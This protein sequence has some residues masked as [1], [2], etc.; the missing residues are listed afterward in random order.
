MLKLSG[1][2]ATVFDVEVKGNIANA[3]IT[4]SKKKED[5]SYENMRW[6]ARFAGKNVSQ[7]AGQLKNGDR[8]EIVEGAVEN[9]YDGEKGYTNVVIFR[10]YKVEGGNE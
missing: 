1:S 10:F 6:L 7:K 8:I 4:T 2:F 5:G 3:K 9:T